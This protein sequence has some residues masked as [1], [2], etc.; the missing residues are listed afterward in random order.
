MPVCLPFSRVVVYLSD[1]WAGRTNQMRLRRIESDGE[2]QLK[3]GPDRGRN[4]LTALGR[5]PNE[6]PRRVFGL[7]GNRDDIVEGTDGF[8]LNWK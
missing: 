4:D 1:V 2:H 3:T 7:C 5:M 6:C 8:E